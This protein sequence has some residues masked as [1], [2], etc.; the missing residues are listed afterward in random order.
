MNRF[1]FAV[2]L[3]ASFNA[4]ADEP[5][6]VPFKDREYRLDPYFTERKLPDESLP[7]AWLRHSLHKIASLPR[8]IDLFESQSAVKDQGQL[9]SC[10]FFAATAL[11]EHAVKKSYSNT[12]ELNLSEEFLIHYVKAVLGSF[13][14]EDGSDVRENLRAFSQSGFLLEEVMPYT[15]SWF[16]RG[17]PCEGGN[18]ETSRQ[19]LCFARKSPNPEQLSE[20]VSP[21]D[22]KLKTSTLSG[23]LDTLLEALAQGIAV[24]VAIPVNRAGWG[25][26][27][28]VTVTHSETLERDCIAN[29][30]HCGGHAVLLTGYDQ[31]R[32]AFRFKNSWGADWGNQGFGWMPFEYVNTYSRPGRFLTAKVSGLSSELQNAPTSEVSEVEGF[33]I[34]VNEA[35]RNR[36][37]GILVQATFR[38]RAKPGTYY[39][40][41]ATPMT[42]NSSGYNSIPDPDS[43]SGKAVADKFYRVSQTEADLEFT[44]AKP[45]EFFISK[46]KLRDVRDSKIELRISVSV[47]NDTDGIQLITRSFVP[48]DNL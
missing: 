23:S 28:D 10:A 45:L 36:E 42:V 3:L 18:P 33:Q 25:G 47:I 22:F 14:Y 46:K 4:S 27:G 9:G 30:S 13:S 15:Y 5:G 24:T 44:P 12:K 40:V 17:M 1:A 11:M 21:S 2:I 19:I 31:N 32:K 6:S 16:E 39:T 41:S 20:L 43:A 34:T 29:P 35:T 48:L 26:D 7:A 38:L 37:A 8:Q